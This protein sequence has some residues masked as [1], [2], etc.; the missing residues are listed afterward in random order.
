MSY[1]IYILD[2][3]GEPVH[4][5]KPHGIGGGTYC[6]T[7]TELWLNITFNYGKIFR[8]EEVFGEKGILCLQGLTVKEALPIVTKAWRALKYDGGEEWTERHNEN[9]TV[10]LIGTARPTPKSYWDATDGNAKNA[11][12]YLGELLEMAPE[13]ATISIS[14]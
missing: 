1:D 5:A 7:S 10:T 9:G 4:V 14:Y 11:L 12:G 6:P 13:D 8:R 2:K 3:K